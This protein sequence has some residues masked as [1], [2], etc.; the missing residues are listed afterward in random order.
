MKKLLKTI[1][2]A[3]VMGLLAALLCGCEL[4]KPMDS[5]YAL[6]V[7]PDEYS[8]LQTSIQSVKD[9][10]N[11]EYAAI[12]YGSYTSTI[13]LLDMD[14]NGTQETAAVF[15]RVTSGEEKP[16]R[17]CLFRRGADDT[18]RL[19]HTVQGEGTA[20]HSVTYQDLNGDGVRELVVSWQMSASVNT[21]A[22][23]QLESGGAV[24]L[25][26]TAYNEGYMTTDLDG[27]GVTEIVVFQRSGSDDE[28]NRAELYRY[29]D[30][31]MMLSSVAP[32]S[33]SIRDVSKTRTGRLS[34]G[35]PA[36]YVTCEVE[37][38]ALT[39]ILVLGESG[40]QNVTLDTAVGFSQSTLR[41][42]TEVS[43]AD[44]NGDGVLDIP[45]PVAL[46][47]RG[48]SLTQYIIYWRQFDS[49]GANTLLAN[50]TYH[51]V[52]D[53][54]YLTLP[55]SWL[56][57][58]TVSRDDSRSLRGERAVVF[59]YR[60]DP[61]ADEPEAFLTVYRLTG[62]NR[63]SRASLPGRTTLYTDSS[64]I[65]SAYLDSAVWDCGI[66]AQDLIRRFRLITPEW[67]MQ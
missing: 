61:A 53:G 2:L 22:A 28:N 11:A 36:I 44:I 60:G 6:P 49:T 40:L 18:Y 16:M 10:L 13:Q 41:T 56:G 67:S 50:A 66:E 47:D 43:A 9:E 46:G 52:T 45:W 42:Y 30:G 27:D 57:K 14:G 54:W 65:Y 33:A 23:Y 7:L 39:D 20:I 25:M 26:S 63:F 64:A 24:D 55:G 5:L 15:L 29:R 48:D 12:T 58:I 35:V 3:A 38:G 32:L 4:F 59:Y 34:D 62:D 17:V 8:Q 1:A 21:L 19:T 51:S 31:A 37:G